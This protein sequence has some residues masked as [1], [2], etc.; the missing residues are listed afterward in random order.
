MPRFSKENSRFLLIALVGATASLPGAARESRLPACQEGA[1]RHDCFGAST[2]NGVKY[3]GEWKRGRFDGQGKLTSPSGWSYVGEFK[4]GKRNGRG[5]Y[6]LPD[7]G[8]YEGEVKNDKPD[9]EGT[10]TFAT[11]MKYEGMF[12]N[13]Q[14]NGQGTQIFPTG[15]KYTGGFKDGYFNGEGTLYEAS[16]AVTRKGLWENGKPVQQASIATAPPAT[17]TPSPATPTARSGTAFRIANGRFVT[18]H[19]V[20]DG[21]VTVKI[22]G[23]PGGRV[24]VSD[25]VNDLALISLPDDHGDV[26]RIRTTKIQLNEA[27]TVAG[28]PLEGMLTGITIT[29]GSISRLSGLKGDTASLQ[30]SAPVQQG[31]SGGP[32]LDASGNVIGVVKSKL[33]VLRVAGLSGDIPQNMN[34]AVSSATLRGF[35]DAKSASYKEVGNERELTGVQIAARATAF[36]VLVECR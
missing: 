7:G 25:P 30:I 19:H 29:N 6:I 8:K 23:R 35:L 36:T 13:G 28:F 10:Q 34:F 15:V 31:N 16:G 2:V 12:K 17:A 18:N 11:G 22:A 20:I 3:E 24:D 1:V 4:E 26:A 33:N 21:C 5:T 14:F 9:G 27:V 32:V